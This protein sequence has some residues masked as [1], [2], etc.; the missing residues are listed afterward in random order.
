MVRPSRNDI[1]LSAANF[2]QSWSSE[3][4]E[5][6]ESQ[7]FWTEFLE[8]FGIRRRRVKA[9]FETHA[10]RS[11]TG[12]AGFIDLLWPGMLLAEQKSRGNDLGKAME[13]ALDYVESLDDKELPRL[14]A[15]SDFARM[16]V[17]DL[18]ED[19]PEMFVF[20]LSELPK[21]IDR[22]LSLAGYT[23]RS[24][25]QEADVD[26]KAAE[27]LGRVYDEMV[28]SGYPDYQVRIFVVRIL[29]LLFGDDTGLWPRNQFAD[30]LRNR[31]SQD[32]SDLGIWLL[33]LFSVVDTD[34]RDRG[35]ALDEDLATFPYINGDLFSEPISAPDTT[36]S[37][38][39]RLLEAS[40]FDWS[41][42][43]PAVFGSMFQS[44]MDP[45]ARRSIGA[46]YTSESNI[47]KVI[48]PLFLDDLERELASCG[49]SR[50]K[51]AKFHEKL[52]DLK[53]LDPA[54]GCGNFLVIAY[55]ELR[56]LEL[57]TLKKL[58][59]D[60][61]QM[62]TD[63]ESWRKVSLDQFF[64]IETEEFPVRIAL[65]AMYLVDHLENEKLGEAFGFN[66]ADLPL[67]KSSTIVRAD[68]LEKPWG[69]V[70]DAG[71]CS[72]IMGNPPFVGKHL[73]DSSQRKS[74]DRVFEGHRQSG[75]LDL[76]AAWFKLAADYLNEGSTAK[77]A[78][79]ATNS[80]T[81][82]E[83]VPA[84]W[85]LLHSLGLHITFAWRTFNWTSEARGAAHVH[86]VVIGFSCSGVDS[87]P[88]ILHEFDERTTASVSRSVKSVNGYLVPADEIYAKP[89]TSPIAR[90]IPSVVYGSKPADGGHL[91]LS[92]EEAEEIRAEDQLAASYIRP[93]LSSV[94][95]LNGRD[96]Y[97]LWLEGSDPTQIRKSPVLTA[98]LK[99]VRQFRL[100]STKKQ[101][102][103]MAES[104]GLFA[105]VRRPTGDFIFIPIHSSAS[106][107]LI[108]MAFVSSEERAVV[109]NSGAYVENADYVQFGILQSE[110][111][112]V[113]QR[114]IG[115]RIKSD[116]RFNN[117]LVYNT[118]PFP[119]VTENG[120]VRIEE[121]VD[122]ILAARRAHASASLSD[123]YSPISMPRDLVIAHRKL[124]KAVDVIF[125]R[126]SEPTESERLSILLTRYSD[127]ERSL[128]LAGIS[129]P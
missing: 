78:F 1:R 67:A 20:D 26:A 127:L 129:S 29:F 115:G 128:M 97:C 118:F 47:M 86:V 71:E 103:E 46:H 30:F 114:S 125:G 58:N 87:S 79:V 13:Q 36:R 105:E 56:Q 50:I 49:S 107:R 11:S 122:E 84:L 34:D 32:G 42:I 14:V 3:S 48:R 91:I 31:T 77:G 121:S 61:V 99:A 90:L 7:T 113:W 80:I 81:Q 21:Q 120:R 83:Q 69:D 40:T 57:A 73:L 108:P 59:P 27:L 106:R 45:M 18:D 55:R 5:R 98:R 9:A 12:G 44:V 96:R 117:R 43:S 22:F 16:G 64:G 62:T 92:S 17:L 39:E 63:L 104:P 109:H 28:D 66:V 8:I 85:P 19:D 94:E 52:G 4:G 68:A 101:T 37:M 23:S 74:L 33:K 95:F 70:L 25:E 116:Y 53:F 10:R 124:D 60:A 35:V 24:F 88:A 93:L 76:V 111:F 112:A 89:R 15:V 41:K 72:F 75:S 82:G 6:A 119:D 65:T 51:L 2:A 102:R 38:R 126:R 123:L 54:S 100:A 110:M